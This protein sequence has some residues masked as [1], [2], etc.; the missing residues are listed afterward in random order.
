MIV[1]HKMKTVNIKETFQLPDLT[2][3]KK[4]KMKGIFDSLARNYD[5]A[6][7]IMSL[8]MHHYWRRHAVARTG[9]KP[10]E[11][12]LD[13]CCGTGM[14]TADLAERVGSSGRITGM[15]LSGEM[16]AIARQRLDKRGLAERVELV[17]GDVAE[18]PFPADS[19]DCVTIG[20]GLRNVHDPERVLGEIQRVLKPGGITV[21]IESAKPMLPVFRTAYYAYLKNWVPLM[22]RVICH[23]QPAYRYLYDSIVDFPAP[24]KIAAIFRRS[25]FSDVEY[26]PLTWGVVAVFTGRKKESQL[27]SC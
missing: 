18:L 27:E 23:N 16:M 24:W 14:I 9:L 11:K 8:G 25:G 19:F 2:E 10:G 12:A 21:A 4:T 26:F 3:I 15:D 7:T 22:G 6:N 13:L 17:Q 1:I 5:L 20:Y